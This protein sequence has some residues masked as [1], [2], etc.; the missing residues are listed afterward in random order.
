MVG[1]ARRRPHAH[2]HEERRGVH[3]HPGGVEVDGRAVAGV[4]VLGAEGAETVRV[5]I[6]VRV[7]V[8]IR[9]MIRS[10]LALALG[11]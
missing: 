10:G 1:L 4:H 11:D 6:R 2:L 5:E 8:K 3:G 7:R 9:V